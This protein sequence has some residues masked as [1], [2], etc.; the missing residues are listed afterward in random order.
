MNRAK[1]ADNANKINA[2]LHHRVNRRVM[3]VAMAAVLAP[4]LMVNDLVVV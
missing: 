4:I 3:V 2:S 1:L